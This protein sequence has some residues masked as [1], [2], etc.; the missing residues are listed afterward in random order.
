MVRARTAASPSTYQQQ[1]AADNHVEASKGLEQFHMLFDVSYAT[2]AAH[3]DLNPE[4]ARHLIQ[5]L[6]LIKMLL[7]FPACLIRVSYSLTQLLQYP[8]MLSP[9]RT[10]AVGSSKIVL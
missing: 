7:S 9:T 8:Y 6:I 1:R 4:A 5:D 3:S 2:S 10:L